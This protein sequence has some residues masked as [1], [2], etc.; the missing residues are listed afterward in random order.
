MCPKGSKI[1]PHFG[2]DVKFV[3]NLYE[4]PIRNLMRAR[5]LHMIPSLKSGLKGANQS[6]L[7]VWCECLVVCVHPA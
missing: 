2:S 3:Q 5:D 4:A 1:L 7:C 6:R